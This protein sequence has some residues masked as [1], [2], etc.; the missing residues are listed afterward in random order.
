MAKIR[1]MPSRR[2]PTARFLTTAGWTG[3]AGLAALAA[4]ATLIALRLLP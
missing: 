1:F 3:L 2:R 4:A